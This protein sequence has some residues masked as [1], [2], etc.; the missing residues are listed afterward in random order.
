[1]VQPSPNFRGQEMGAHA[2][3]GPAVALGVCQAQP[4]Q[5]AH[6]SHSP[7]HVH[8]PGA[9]SVQPG[10][11]VIPGIRRPCDLRS[12]PLS[13]VW[14]SHLEGEGTGLDQYFQGPAKCTAHNTGHWA[15]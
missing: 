6:T 8:F 10:E 15:P 7:P 1:M 11:K 13:G 14:F 3:Q 4:R 12:P 9:R 5:C 2:S